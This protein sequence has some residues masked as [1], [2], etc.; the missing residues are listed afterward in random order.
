MKKNTQAQRESEK[1]KVIAMRNFFF[2]CHFFFYLSGWENCAGKDEGKYSFSWALLVRIQ[3]NTVW[4]FFWGGQ[5][6]IA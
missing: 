6:H 2:R 4:K 1:M 5:F 3:F